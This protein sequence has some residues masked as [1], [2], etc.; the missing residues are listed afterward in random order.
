MNYIITY[1]V[2]TANGHWRTHKIEVYDMSKVYAIRKTIKELGYE[3]V[4]TV[5]TVKE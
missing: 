1:E 2:P 4:N 5:L 3:Y